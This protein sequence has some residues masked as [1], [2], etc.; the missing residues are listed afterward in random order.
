MRKTLPLLLIAALVLTSCGRIRD[1]RIN[2]FN[3]FGRA[4]A[5]EIEGTARNPL[6]PRRRGFSIRDTEDNRTP[7]AQITGLTVERLPGGAI[8][9]V[10]GVSARQGAYNV[11]L[12]P[13]EGVEVPPDTRR[14]V[15]VAD[16]RVNPVGTTL[17]RTVTA[18]TKLT[19]QELEELRQ[20]EVVGGQNVLTTRR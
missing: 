8:V 6:I 3:W 7:I 19:D 18:A 13:V 12:E 1:S 17:S 11:A 16:Q 4:E 14:Y 10:T 9:Q 20:I 15:L 5:T 2:P